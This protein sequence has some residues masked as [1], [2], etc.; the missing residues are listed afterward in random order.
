MNLPTLPAL[1][2]AFALDAEAFLVLLLLLALVAAR[3]RRIRRA[4]AKGPAR[5]TQPGA[6]ALPASPAS[7]VAAPAAATASVA[8]RLSEAELVAALRGRLAGTPLDAS[9]GAAGVPAAP[10]R[11][12][13]VENGHELL[14]HLDS[15]AVRLR[16]GLM[17]ALLE[18]EA[19]QTG[20]TTVVV[21]FALSE[22]GQGGLVAVTEER[23]RG[24]PAVVAHWGSP[25]QEALW[26]ALLGIATDAAGQHG[27][28][29][30][31]LAAGDG[32]LQL[33][34]APAEV[35]VGAVTS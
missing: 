8:V 19:D 6:M 14:V 2:P 12:I 16:P 4:A 30:T 25:L 32:M 10:D 31:E 9:Q 28:M 21:P 29:P 13:W 33:R 35:P 5:P 7:P 3:R 26:A 24:D 15:L 22:P 17:L 27:H 23:P 1:P 20:R 11:V 18:V 34:S